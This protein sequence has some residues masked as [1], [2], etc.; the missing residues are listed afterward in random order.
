M[1]SS[2]GIEPASPDH[3]SGVLPF[4]LQ[5]DTYL[6]V[7]AVKRLSALSFFRKLKCVGAGDRTRT[8]TLVAIDPKSIVSAIPPHR[9]IHKLT[10]TNDTLEGTTPH[11]LD[12]SITR[13]SSPQI[14][15]SCEYSAPI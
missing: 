11:L 4:E 6:S 13:S 14:L 1:C 7:Q 3:A 2:A 12:E 15:L 8:C 9:R 10:N 5:R